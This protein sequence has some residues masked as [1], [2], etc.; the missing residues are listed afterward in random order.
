MKLEVTTPSGTRE[1][2]AGRAA[3]IE[4]V[5]PHVYSIVLNGRSYEARV[6]MKDDEYIV[7]I[8]GQSIAIEIND[9]RDFRRGA[10]NGGDSNLRHIMA[11]MPG[12]VVRLLVDA[13]DAVEEGQ[14]LIVIEAMKMQN[15]LRSPRPGIVSK[16]EVAIGG[17][18]T[19]GQVLVTLE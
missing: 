12:K 18:V 8:D 15:E 10:R 1:W 16:V 19:A 3:T 17:T 9:P 5:E 11:S 6:V 7:E 4:E 14:G 2:T 13:G